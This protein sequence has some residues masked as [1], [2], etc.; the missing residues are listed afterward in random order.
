MTIYCGVSLAV[1]I[2]LLSIPDHPITILGWEVPMTAGWGQK[3]A[4]AVLAVGGGYCLWDMYST[5]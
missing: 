3:A 5:E 1:G 4:G 2:H